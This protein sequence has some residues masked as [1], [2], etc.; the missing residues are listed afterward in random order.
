MMLGLKIKQQ[1]DTTKC[2]K[3][4]PPIPPSESDDLL[5]KLPILLAQIKSGNNS[6]KLKNENRQILYPLYQN[7]KIT[8]KF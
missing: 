2:T 5:T 8:K 7:N 6:C 1:N 4:L 3:N